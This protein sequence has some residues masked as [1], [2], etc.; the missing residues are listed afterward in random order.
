MAKQILQNVTVSVGGVALG[1]SVKSV[2]ISLSADAKEVSA[3][4]DGWV[5]RIAGLKDGSIKIDFYQDYA[6]SSVEATL[7]PL[8]GSLATVA[9]IPNGGT[10]SATNP[11]YTAVCLVNQIMPVSGAVGDVATQ[12][13]TWPTSGTVVKATA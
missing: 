5:Q 8:L 13:I 6:A 2:E 11:S 7:Y 1:T 4:G 3:F 12:S 10:A 9:I